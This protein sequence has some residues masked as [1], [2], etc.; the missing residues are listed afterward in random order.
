MI[1]LQIILGAFVIYCI[2]MC[3]L[4]PTE[5][6]LLE[7]E[8]RQQSYV[9]AQEERK[10]KEIQEK[11]DILDILKTMIKDGRYKGYIRTSWSRSLYGGEI[12]FC[13]GCSIKFPKIL[14]FDGRERLHIRNY[15]TFDSKDDWDFLYDVK[16]LIYS[17][18]CLYDLD[19]DGYHDSDFSQKS[20]KYEEIKKSL[21]IF[22]KTKQEPK[23]YLYTV[24]ELKQNGGGFFIYQ[25]KILRIYVTDCCLEDF[26]N[27]NVYLCQDCFGKYYEIDL[28]T[29]QNK[30]IVSLGV[31]LGVSIDEYHRRLQEA[32]NKKLKKC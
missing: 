4:K 7:Q 16:Q 30:D 13:N 12:E 11:Q 26:V 3:L 9:K 15:G 32:Y 18:P 10:N 23:E 22:S 2:G 14:D 29:I 5:L 19:M 27:R 8:Q 21:P 28:R 25:D 31:C 20:N 1:Y 6:E 24:E 17:K